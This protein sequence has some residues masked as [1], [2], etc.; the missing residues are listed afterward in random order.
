MP[1]TP[2]KYESV[3]SALLFR[4][5]DRTIF[6]DMLCF[7]AGPCHCPSLMLFQHE[8]EVLEYAN[9]FLHYM[10]FRSVRDESCMEEVGGRE[11]S[12]RKCDVCKIF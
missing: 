4:P 3:E 12:S 6:T 8:G 7:I 2:P 9:A 5:V 1:I 10:L 11:G